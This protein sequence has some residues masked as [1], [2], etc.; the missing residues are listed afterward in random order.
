[1]GVD[2]V[3]V[4]NKYST[5]PNQA[6]HFSRPFGPRDGLKGTEKG[7]IKDKIIRAFMGKEVTDEEL[8]S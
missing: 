7:V 3:D 1:V 4:P 8:G 2:R 5:R 6:R